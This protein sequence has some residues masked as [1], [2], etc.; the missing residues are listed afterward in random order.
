M[1]LSPR[2]LIS[3]PHLLRRSFCALAATVLLSGP[4]WAAEPSPVGEWLVK[5]GVARIRIE[6]CDNHMWGVVS[7][8]M[9][10]GGN[11]QYNPDPAKRSRPTLGMPIIL[12]MAQT[13]P[14]K[15]EGE[16]YNSTNGKTYSAN[17][18]LADQNPDVL[19]V[20]GC[21]L[22]FLCGGQNWTR[23]PP[24]PAPKANGAR[25]QATPARNA[26]A[27]QRNGAPKTTG[28]TG[29]GKGAAAIDPTKDVC[30][31]VTADATPSKMR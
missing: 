13:G 28:S 18:S 3:N 21:I 6:N 9:E 10:S 2:Q 24:E 30:A 1:L 8:E 17:I 16:I 19:Q 4:V 29:T 15:W 31:A 26:A 20:Q 12:G 23:M 11:D 25:A 27:P 14:N 22:G 7:W 5:D